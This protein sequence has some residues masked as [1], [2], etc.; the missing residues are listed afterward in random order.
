[1]HI[2][3]VSDAW[4]PQ[5]NGVVRT[6][7]TTGDEL[8]E[9]G[10][11]VTFVTPENFKS[12]PL[13]GNK[14]IVFS[15]F[16]RRKISRMLDQL[17]P[18]AIHIAVEGPL[19]YAARSYCI[20][21][22]LSFSTA[23]H[24]KFPEYLKKQF[25]VPESI[26]YKAVRRFHKPSAAVMVATQSLEDDL[27]TRGFKNI[28]RWSRGVD[29]KQFTPQTELGKKFYPQD[30]AR[31]IALYVGRVSV[32]KAIEDFLILDLP[33]TKVVV[34]DGP[35]LEELKSKFPEV[36]FAG[37]Q[38]GKNLAAHYSGADVFVFPSRSDTF[39]LVLLEALASGLPVA[40]YPVTGPVDV[41]TSD[42]A[43]CLNED[44]QEAVLTALTL[45]PAD[46]VEFAKTYSW[47]ASAEQF[48]SNLHPNIST[49]L[50]LT[51]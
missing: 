31:P 18:D 29:M 41:I 49:K 7:S 17:H 23:Y 44:L 33:G 11:T 16:P 24:T 14:E 15:L 43:G 2:V 42:K 6:L 22:G 13:P 25:G 32:E 40:A 34:G 1:M 4:F 12:V 46:C 20:K 28:Q 10:H 9:M 47:R 45:S 3:I 38:K 50:K 19:G 36:H 39:G 30:F 35:Q 21:R 37:V 8:R 48:F 27:K 26:T 5:V 51:A